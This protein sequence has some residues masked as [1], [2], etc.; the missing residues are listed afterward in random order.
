MANSSICGCSCGLC[1]HAAEPC[2]ACL[3]STLRA[4]G[5]SVTLADEI[6]GLAH[7]IPYGGFQFSPLHDKLRELV[8]TTI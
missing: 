6:K 2:D 4:N 1:C 5:L 3:V 7:K 8:T